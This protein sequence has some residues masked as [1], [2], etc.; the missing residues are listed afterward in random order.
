MRPL[1]AKQ[2]AL[3]RICGPCQLMMP[4]AAGNLERSERNSEAF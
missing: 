3:D 4:P 2:A 1:G